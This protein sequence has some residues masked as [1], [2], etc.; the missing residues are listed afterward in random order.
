MSASRFARISGLGRS[1]PSRI[2]SNDELSTFVDTSDEWIRSRT[3]IA[4]RRFVSDGET[5]GTM[6]IQAG[7]EALTAS[8][9]PPSE[10][11]LVIVATSTPDHQVFPATASMVQDA[12]GL[13]AAGAYDLDAACS[14]FVYALVTAGQFI[15]SGSYEHVLVIGSDTLSRWLDFTDRTTCVLFG[16]GAGAALVSA[17]DRAGGLRSF[18]LG[19]DGRG[20]KHLYVPAG[21]SRKP[22]SADTV[23]AHEHAIRMNG[24]QVYRFS[25]T[26]PADALVQAADR[27]G[28][29]LADLDLI[30]AHQANDRILQ[31]VAHN[32]ELPES[33]FY[34]N[35]KHYGNTSAAS[36]PLALYDAR[37][38]G[39]LSDGAMVGLMGFGAGL[40]WA[41]A[42]WQWHEPAP[43]PAGA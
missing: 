20:A 19:S 30:V 9:V 10:V 33:L 15:A 18:V 3:G 39:R 21:G 25:T 5:T 27:A 17:T 12:L 32:L 8:R 36:I 31:T 42:I 13:T 24:H 38:E 4:E 11:G 14:G 2:V 29:R 26:T 23:A 1:L 41:T 35:V 16:D 37:A 40:T 28:V 34:S 43:R 6:A 7:C 22:P